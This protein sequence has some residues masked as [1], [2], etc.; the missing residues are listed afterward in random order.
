VTATL[1]APFQ[2]PFMAR[3][4]AELVLLGLL[5]ATV[6][7][8]VLLRRLAF[9]ADAL[10]HTVFPGVVIGYLL[11][12]TAGITPG[13]LVAALVTTVLLTAV[14]STGRVHSDAALAILLTC[15][16]A[17]GVVLVSRRSSY[18]SDLTAFLFGR[19][20]TVDGGEIAWTATVAAV[21]VLT[22][23]ALSKE[24]LFVA[25][26]PVGAAAAGYRPVVLDM[27]IN[28]LVA[29]TVVVAIRSVGTLLVIAIIIIP[30]ATG[31]A[32]SARLPV[33]AGV[34]ALAGAAAAWIGLGVS[35]RVSLATDARLAAGPTVVGVLIVMYV[36]AHGWRAAR[37][38]LGRRAVGR[39]AVGRRTAGRRT[40]IA[41]QDAGAG[42]G[43]EAARAIR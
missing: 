7:V 8:F 40:G 37:S 41:E 21:V 34:A 2:L 20:L 6:G 1:L 9:L 28:G 27:V 11:A 4:L 19:P 26:D 13:A 10:T 14:V 15:F 3:A 36:A 31:R 39:R 18:T 43:L 29:L 22:L 5:G 17:V 32:L 12:G 35:F 42:A 30:A 23:A 24:L 25:F 16:F 38:A 33:I